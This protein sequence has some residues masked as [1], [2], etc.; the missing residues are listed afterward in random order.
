MFFSD[1]KEV[2]VVSSV[3]VLR[4]VRLLLIH[5]VYSSVSWWIDRNLGSPIK[6]AYG[7]VVDIILH[8]L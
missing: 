6:E 7:G 1:A 4:V 5:R 8:F 3:S 2:N